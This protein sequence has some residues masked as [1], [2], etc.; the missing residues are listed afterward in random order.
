M[1]PPL[2][3]PYTVSFIVQ[4]VIRIKNP[5]HSLIITNPAPK[6]NGFGY[7]F[8]IILHNGTDGISEH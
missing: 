2:L 8:K 4:R 3:T 1:I 7:L 5:L 6:S